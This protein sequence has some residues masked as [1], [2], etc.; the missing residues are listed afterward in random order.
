MIHQALIFDFDGL[1]LDTETPDFHSWREVYE[2]HGVELTIGAWADCV[3]KPA[4][5]FDPCEHL[6]SLLGKPVDR[7]AVRARRYSRLAEMLEARQVLPGVMEYVAEGRRLGLRLGV[8]SSAP[9]AWVTHHLERLGLIDRFASIKCADDV[10]HAKPHPELYEATLAAL[11]VEARQA[12]AFEDSPHGVTAAKQAG[13]FC[14]AV[15]NPITRQLSLDHADLLLASLSELALPD[16]LAKVAA[17]ES[18]S[19]DFALSKRYTS[20]L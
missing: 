1:I 19:L 8:A 15:P 10:T 7:V 2:A 18:R 20:R 5:A 4:H 12:I 11:D 17:G 3:G 13:V 6:E 9:R 14:V 16:L